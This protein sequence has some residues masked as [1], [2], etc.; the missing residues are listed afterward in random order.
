MAC[1]TRARID[2]I[3]S[4]LRAVWLKNTDLRFGQLI[5]LLTRPSGSCPEVFHL[6]DNLLHKRLRRAK[7]GAPLSSP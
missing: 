5:V 7:S 3:L 1:E 4:D 2:E 6:E